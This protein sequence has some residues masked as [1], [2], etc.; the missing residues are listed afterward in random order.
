MLI[1]FKGRKSGK[2]YSIPVNYARNNDTLLVV[3]EQQ[4]KWW[5]NFEDGTIVS[6]SVKR[7][8][9]EGSGKAVTDRKQV[10]KHIIDYLKILPQ[11]AKYFDVKTNTDGSFNLEDISK[12]AKDKIGIRIQVIN[13]IS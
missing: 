2:Q 10:M 13:T 9:L 6:I 8:M 1:T 3:T 7:Q 4:R 12:A 5:K 11:Y